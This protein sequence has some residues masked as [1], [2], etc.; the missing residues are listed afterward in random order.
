M[1]HRSIYL[2][3]FHNT[4]TTLHSSR[5]AIDASLSDMNSAEEA[6]YIQLTTGGFDFA[7]APFVR[8]QGMSN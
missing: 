2:L 7:V 1:R 4:S 3:F 6:P 5:E 8:Q